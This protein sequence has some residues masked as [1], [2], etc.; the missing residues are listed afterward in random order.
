[1]TTTININDLA[2]RLK[3]Q[4][5]EGIAPA[6]D[7]IEIAPALLPKVAEYLKNSMD[8]DYFDMVTAADYA[9]RF[10]LIYRLQSIK[11]NALVSLKVKTGKDN[12]AVPSMANL[13]QGAGL[14]EREIYDLFGIAFS[15]HPDLRRIVLWEG[16]EGYPLRKD[17][18]DKVY[19]AGN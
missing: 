7:Y 12:P 16:Y 5:G 8:F 18:K 10:E 13:W 2:A 9:D 3:T 11:N 14:Q 17:F 6:G 19:G 15:G 1:M 4:F